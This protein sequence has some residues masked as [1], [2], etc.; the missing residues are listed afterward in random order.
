M[1][2]QIYL[3]VVLLAVVALG[4]ELVNIHLSSKLASDSVTVRKIKDNIAKLDEKN[5]I[6]YSKVLELTSYEMVASK[7]A[8]LG[9]EENHSYISLH[10]QTK[11]SYS[12]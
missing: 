2:R 12:R 4:L 8:D 7:A 3:S 1:L 9:F 10:N 11:F 6:L 5:Q